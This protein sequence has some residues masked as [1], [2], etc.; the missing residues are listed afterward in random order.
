MDN[1]VKKQKIIKLALVIFA[2]VIVVFLGLII[3]SKRTQVAGKGKTSIDDYNARIEYRDEMNCNVGEQ[4]DESH[5]ILAATDGWD[6][7][8]IENYDLNGEK[9]S[10]IISEDKLYVDASSGKKIYSLDYFNYEYKTDLFEDLKL[11]DGD[12]RAVRCYAQDS[13]K[14]DLRN[15]RQYEDWSSR[16][17]PNEE[18]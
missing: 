8:S 16:K 11:S 15:S 5:F 10:I 1:N 18:N 14:Y 17:V 4:K 2:C 13:S 7:V 9:V 6:N 12:S 3:Y